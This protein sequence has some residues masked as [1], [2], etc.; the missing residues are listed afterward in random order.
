[1]DVIEWV[2]PD[3]V[4]VKAVREAVEANRESG[5]KPTRPAK[6][7]PVDYSEVEIAAADWLL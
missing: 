2:K 7:E 6:P 5:H 1:M 4:D 3:P